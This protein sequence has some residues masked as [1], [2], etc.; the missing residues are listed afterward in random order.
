MFKPGGGKF[1]S[2][3]LSALSDVRPVVLFIFSTSLGAERQG[4]SSTG[5][6]RMRRRPTSSTSAAE[7]AQTPRR[8]EGESPLLRP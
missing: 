4:L 3:N 8:R 7:S 6:V 5:S 1:P 2:T